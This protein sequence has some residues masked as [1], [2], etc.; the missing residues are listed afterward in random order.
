MDGQ[1]RAS[2]AGLSQYCLAGADSSPSGCA[3][4][5]SCG[6]AT[7]SAL[8]EAYRHGLGQLADAIF[9]LSA[10]K[11]QRVAHSLAKWQFLCFQTLP[12]DDTPV[13]EAAGP[14]P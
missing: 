2:W 12:E 13:G 7:G 1:A 4:S 6:W 14:L 8:P 9:R 3:K 5:T 10:A 11:L